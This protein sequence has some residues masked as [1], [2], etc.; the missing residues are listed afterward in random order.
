[1]E[2]VVVAE[3]EDLQELQDLFYNI[4]NPAKM[5]DFFIG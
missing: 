2:V 3:V 5:Q 1:M 4:K